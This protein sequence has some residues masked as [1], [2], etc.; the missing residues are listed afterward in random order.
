MNQPH[1]KWYEFDV[2]VVRILIA[3]FTYNKHNVVVSIN[4][5]EH[6]VKFQYY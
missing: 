2:N 6:I 5:S 1:F 4:E 3:I